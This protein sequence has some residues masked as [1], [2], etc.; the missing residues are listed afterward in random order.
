[1][2][3]EPIAELYFRQ[4]MQTTPWREEEVV[5][6]GRRHLQP[7]LVAW[8]GDAHASYSYSGS[9]LTPNPWMPLLEEL[10]QLVE[11]RARA[12]FNSVLLN[13]YRNESDRMGWH[14]DDEPELGK[15]PVIASIS[16]GAPRVFQMRHKSRK[17]LGIRS[18][19]L[20]SGSL[21]VMRGETQR[22][23]LHSIRKESKP[24]G[25]RINLTF[26]KISR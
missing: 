18:Y 15:E 24:I 9:T 2:L 25:P 22:H 7:R 8:F 16:L 4:L 17:E 11:L 19:E 13:L 12:E 23:W 20:T 26:R 14:S 5:V 10:K 6:W 1:M 3:A 21:L